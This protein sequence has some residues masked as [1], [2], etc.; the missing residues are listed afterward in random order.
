MVMKPIAHLLGG[1]LHALTI[2]TYTEDEMN[3]EE[4]SKR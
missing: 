3:K 4:N 2:K 1:P